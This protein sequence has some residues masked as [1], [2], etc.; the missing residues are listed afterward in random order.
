MIKNY[1]VI[2]NS[3]QVRIQFHIYYCTNKNTKTWKERME[4]QNS[5]YQSKSR[6]C[7][8]SRMPSTIQINFAIQPEDRYA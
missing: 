6:L 2:S 5:V 8:Y 3:L 7:K 1:S 4:L